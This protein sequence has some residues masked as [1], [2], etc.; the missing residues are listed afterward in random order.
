MTD[1]V[2]GGWGGRGGWE[3][4]GDGSAAVQSVQGV[5]IGVCSGGLGGCGLT[6]RA[7]GLLQ[8]GRIET[9]Y[10]HLAPFISVLLAI[11]PLTV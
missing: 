4:G 2:G 3:G 6:L 5:G 8:P 1:G 9:I 10:A 11:L 7:V